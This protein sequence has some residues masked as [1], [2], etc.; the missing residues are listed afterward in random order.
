MSKPSN[1]N[2]FKWKVAYLDVGQDLELGIG[3]RN[4]RVGLEFQ[5]YLI[6]ISLIRLLFCTVTVNKYNSYYISKK[7]IKPVSLLYCSV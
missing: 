3:L 1:F 2:Q 6:P 7:Q 4:G 5:D